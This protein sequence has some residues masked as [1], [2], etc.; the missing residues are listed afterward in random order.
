MT[1]P[2]RLSLA[3]ITPKG[4][5]SWIRCAKALIFLGILSALTRELSIVF[6]C[7]SGLGNTGTGNLL[8]SSVFAGSQLIAGWVSGRESV[9]LDDSL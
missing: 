7:T 9:G 1:V 4:G 3:I 2:W 8:Q 5:S 6:S